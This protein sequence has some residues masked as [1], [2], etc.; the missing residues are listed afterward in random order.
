MEVVF[1][2]DIEEICEELVEEGYVC[3][4]KMKNVKKKFIKLV[5]DKY[6]V[7]DGIEI[8]VGKNNK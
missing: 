7:S 3:N 2:K 8:F 6:V 5:L 1:L 4:C